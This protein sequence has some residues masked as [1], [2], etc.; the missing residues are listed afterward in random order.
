MRIPEQYKCDVE[1]CEQVKGPTNGWWLI[2]TDSFTGGTGISIR[3]FSHLK[4]CLG[5]WFHCCG[6]EH[7]IQ[8]A[9]ELMGKLKHD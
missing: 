1:G 3:P 8:K 9:S 2:S 4:D 5:A 6:Q 7:A